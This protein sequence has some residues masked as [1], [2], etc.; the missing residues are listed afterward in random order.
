VEKRHENEVPPEA[1]IVHVTVRL[2]PRGGS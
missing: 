1:G 2:V